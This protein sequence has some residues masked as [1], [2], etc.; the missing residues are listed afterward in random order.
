MPY[1][2]GYCQRIDNLIPDAETYFC[3]KC[4]KS[5]TMHKG[6]CEKHNFIAHRGKA[7]FKLRPQKA[8]SE[9]D[10]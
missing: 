8:P 3:L 1:L 6:C 2:C 7:T 9:N 4:K 10:A 5:K